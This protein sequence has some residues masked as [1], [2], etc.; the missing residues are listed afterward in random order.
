ME[1]EV[2]QLLG[3]GG[4]RLNPSSAIRESKQLFAAFV[5]ELWTGHY[6]ARY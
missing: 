1:R 3:W 4:V 6:K 2:G 5:L